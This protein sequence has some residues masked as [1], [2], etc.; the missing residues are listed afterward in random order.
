M[1][2][3][4]SV[5]LDANPQSD[6]F[7][8]GGGTTKRSLTVTSG[9]M[10]LTGGGASTFTFPGATSVL[11]GIT[12]TA[13]A[14]SIIFAGSTLMGEDNAN[15]YWD[16]SNKTLGL[17]TT[18]SGAISGTNPSFRIKGTGTTSGTSSF[19]IQ[20]SSSSSLFFVRN[21]GLTTITGIGVVTKSLTSGVVGLTDAATVATDASLGNH[22]RVTLGGNR[23]L[24]NPTNPTDGQKCTWE[25]IQDG[26]GSRTITLDTKFAFGTDITSIT[27]TT[28]LNK[29]DFLGCIYN[30]AADKWFV[31][32]FIKG[33]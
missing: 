5:N 22:F 25:I 1:A 19:E 24:G 14:G 7:I 11:L 31:V 28:T 21:D 27:L 13:T 16:N 10:T 3:N 32:S 12:A 26:T 4:T 23:T 8:L 15:L 30:S 20:N 17:G 33:Y 18:R 2:R 9:D 6:G 29:R